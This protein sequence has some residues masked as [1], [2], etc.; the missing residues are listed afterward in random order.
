[1]H[2]KRW[3]WKDRKSNLGGGK[4]T[5]WKPATLPPLHLNVICNWFTINSHLFVQINVVCLPDFPYLASNFSELERGRNT[6][7][8]LAWQVII[9]DYT[10]DL[11][12]EIGLIWKPN[13]VI[14]VKEKL[15]PHKGIQRRCYE[16]PVSLIHQVPSVGNNRKM[17]AKKSIITA[18]PPEDSQRGRMRRDRR[19]TRTQH[20]D[21]PTLEKFR[22]QRLYNM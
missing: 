19:R 20:S 18:E 10:P 12:Q 6:F 16:T 8:G 13:W 17:S 2:I 22:A 14:A 4:S 9:P 7:L 11:W 5:Q 21:P 15:T 1:M 3:R